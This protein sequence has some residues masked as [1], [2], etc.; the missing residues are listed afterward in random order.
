VINSH[1]HGANAKVSNLVNM[2]GEAQHE[3][4][5]ISDSDIVVPRDYLKAV[6]AALGEPGVGLVTCLYRGAAT[7]GI[8]SRMAAAAID[9]HFLPNVLVGLKLGRASAR[10]S[11]LPKRHW[12]NLAVC[13]RLPIDWPTT[14]PWAV[15]CGGPA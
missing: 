8:W 1:R 13:N 2:H 5:V 10:R 12:L 11:R 3:V 6:V 9:Y 4:L 14:M 7:A 15:R